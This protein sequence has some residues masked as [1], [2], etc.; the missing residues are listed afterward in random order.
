MISDFLVLLGNETLGVSVCDI[1]CGCVSQ[2]EGERKRNCA[3][4]GE[5]S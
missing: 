5:D 4:Q 1:R 3:G 2:R